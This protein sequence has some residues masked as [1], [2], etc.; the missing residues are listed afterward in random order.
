MQTNMLEKTL[1][2]LLIVATV[3]IWFW[4]TWRVIEL[5]TV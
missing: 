5:L 3:T 4:I 1:D 2:A